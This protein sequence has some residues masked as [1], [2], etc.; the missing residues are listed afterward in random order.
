MKKNLHILSL[1]CP[2]A[3]VDTEVMLG[4]LRNNG[5]TLTPDPARADAI[6]INTC[7]FLQAS[8][9]ESIDEILAYA[10][11]KKEGRCKKL[12]VTGCLP[13]RFAGEADELR[14]SLPEVDAFLTT[15][16]LNEIVRAVDG[17]FPD[18]DR[19]YFLDR[20][21][22]G[23]QSYAYLKV[24]E[25][26][27]RRCSFCT[28]PSIRGAQ[29]S[30]PIASLIREAEGLAASGVREIVLVAQELTGYGTDIG[31]KDGIIQVIDAL[32]KIDGIEWVR[33]LYAYPW[34]FGDA[35]LERVG[36]GKLLPYVDIPLQHVSQHI[37]NDMRR[38][39]TRE[40][41]DRLLR[42]LRE[43]PGMVLR[44][45]L[46]A[47]YPGET[48]EDVGELIDWIRDIRFDRLGVFVYS[49]EPGTPAGDRPDQVPEEVRAARRDRIMAAQQEISASMMQDL[50]GQRLRVLVDGY[51]PEHEL[52]LQGRYFGQA[53]EV[54]GQVYLSYE[55]CDC[56]MAQTGE[57]VEVE[58]AEA[59]E[60]DLVG[61]VIDP[62]SEEA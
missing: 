61:N 30:R 55:N 60:Y 59:T 31:L 20:R 51:S 15:R 34:N 10:D 35:L 3:R 56:D 9:E 1:G 52:V 19:D 21:L 40:A 25:G 58:I 29:V 8:I 37:L 18:P 24:S 41:Q 57:F 46:I 38:H 47:G 44:T 27:N 22:A 12:V 17:V 62:A 16:R 4:L 45:S 6:V 26:C 43:I 39:V 2:K 48:E 33:M 54:D 42:R 53:P 32:E 13:S 36:Q 49:A 5:W 28:I 11:Y 7:A 50:V 14:A 23:K